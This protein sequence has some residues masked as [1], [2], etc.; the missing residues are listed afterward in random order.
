MGVYNIRWGY[1]TD[2]HRKA[3]TFS[4]MERGKTVDLK[5]PLRKENNLIIKSQRTSSESLTI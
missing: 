2:D 3:I 1:I 5:E 4:A